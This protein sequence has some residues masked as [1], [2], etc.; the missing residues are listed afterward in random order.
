MRK[1]RQ[2]G[3]PV[4][5]EL[6]SKALWSRQ[7]LCRCLPTGPTDTGDEQVPDAYLRAVMPLDEYE[8]R[9]RDLEQRLS[10]LARQEEQLRDDAERQ[11]QLAGLAA[12]LEAFRER[13][14]RGLAQASFEQSRQLVLLLIDRMVVTDT[15]VEIRYVL[16]TS[17]ESEH[18]RFCHLRK[19]YF[20]DPANPVRQE[21]PVPRA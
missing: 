14:Q 19:D 16:P 10:A 9:R 20:H 15:E 8:R 13:V 17:P 3:E 4:H 5:P 18:V 7:G 21:A 6:E 12:S 11:R 1:R 2:V